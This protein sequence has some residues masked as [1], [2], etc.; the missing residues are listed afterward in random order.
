MARRSQGAQP[1]EI[2][3]FHRRGRHH[4]DADNHAVVALQHDVHL[5][6]LLVTEMIR[7]QPQVRARHEL[8][9]LG[10]Y[11]ALQQAAKNVAVPH[12]PVEA[13]SAR[14]REQPGIKKMQ[15]RRFDNA[16]Q[17]ICVPRLQCRNEKHLFEQADVT[18]AGLVAD[19]D[20][21]AKLRVGL[22]GIERCLVIEGDV[23][24]PGVTHLAHQRRLARTARA[25]DEHDRSV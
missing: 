24:P 20:A 12:E 6:P 11:K 1:G 22:C 18:L 19:I 3:G 7:R 8:Q 15:F 16:L 17:G 9:D 21:A 10:E 4:F 23:G 13:Q 14:G 25:D 5:V 2:G